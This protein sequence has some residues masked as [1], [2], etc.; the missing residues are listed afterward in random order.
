M[1][2]C[3]HQEYVGLDSLSM[4]D[5]VDLV[6]QSKDTLDDVWRQTDFQPYSE[7]RMIR[8][9]DIIGGSLPDI[10][11]PKRGT[12]NIFCWCCIFFVKQNDMLVC[13]YL[14]KWTTLHCWNVQFGEPKLSLFP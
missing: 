10:H 13:L 3:V 2:V 12:K 14:V 1:C 9:M 5:V 7:L 6:E 4:S 11:E 8:L